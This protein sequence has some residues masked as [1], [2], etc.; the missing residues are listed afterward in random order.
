MKSP[1]SICFIANFTKTYFFDAIAQALQKDGLTIYWMAT[2]Q[3]IYNFLVEKYGY[4]SVLLINKAYYALDKAP[5]GEFKINE[6]L[7]GDRVLKYDLANGSKF[8]TNIQAPIYDFLKE[9]EISF[10]F[11][12]ITWAHEILIHRICTQMKD[13]ACTFLNPHVIRMPNDR[14]AFFVNERQSQLL[15][16]EQNKISTTEILQVVKPTYLKH[17][18]N[19]L[20]KARSITG[21][22][23]R[24]KRFFTNEN[25]DKEDP[26]LLSNE[27]IRFV[28]RTKEELYK[29]TYRMVNRTSFEELQNE[30]YIFIGL[31]K[32]PEASV[33]V[34][35]RY[36]ED[37]MQNI[38]NIWRVLPHGWKL[39]IKEHTNAIGDRS[40]AFYKTLQQ[41]LGIVIVEEKTDSYELIRN[42]KAVVTVT[43]TIA[44][45]AALM[46]IPALTFAP[47]FFNRINYCQQVTLETLSET[48]DLTGLINGLKDSEDNRLDFTNY[49]LNNSFKGILSDPL[50]NPS[51]LEVE[52]IENIS[53]AYLLAIK[54]ISNKIE[55]KKMPIRLS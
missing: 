47:V 33:D 52:N 1:K 43:G 46:Q 53:N 7:Y 49:L 31:H 41:L 36:Y 39:V 35:G 12:E 22:A 40:R 11:G 27:K 28:T 9:N 4:S 8:L 25:I 54:A 16:V 21:R 20:A 26:T 18:N 23:D 2:N 29:E 42:A 51:I 24:I 6:L 15:E 30:A 55:Q 37:Q 13:L 14:F 5:I 19:R 17:V 3:K 34:F 38:Q 45:E 44:L 10:V 48:T 50:L 32:Q